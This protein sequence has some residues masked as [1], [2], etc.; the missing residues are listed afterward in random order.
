MYER[1]STFPGSWN[2]THRLVNDNMEQIKY[3]IRNWTTFKASLI[4]ID[5]IW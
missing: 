1:F 3:A 4:L 2:T 5:K